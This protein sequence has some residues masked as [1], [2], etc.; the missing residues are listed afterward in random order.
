M[1]TTQH[2]Q[3]ASLYTHRPASLPI[4]LQLSTHLLSTDCL[5]GWDGVVASHPVLWDMCGCPWAWK[6]LSSNSLALSAPSLLSF[7]PYCPA[8]CSLFLC[9][10]PFTTL[11]RKNG[12]QTGHASAV[13][14]KGV[15]TWSRTRPLSPS[16]ASQYGTILLPG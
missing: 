4:S 3:S 16:S 8:L 1:V 14:S 11:E 6:P 2:C 10:W 13:T 7:A 15:C 9:T 5:R 12:S